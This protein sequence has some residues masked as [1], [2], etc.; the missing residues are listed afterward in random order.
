MA[1]PQGTGFAS[2]TRMLMKGGICPESIASSPYRERPWW[3][4][5][6]LLLSAPENYCGSD[7]L[8]RSSYVEIMARPQGTGFARSAFLRPVGS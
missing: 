2:H 6:S 7:R 5:M 1:R 4:W 3:G 8:I